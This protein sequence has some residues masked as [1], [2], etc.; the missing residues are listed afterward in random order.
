[1]VLWGEFFDEGGVFGVL[2]SELFLGNSER[3]VACIVCGFGV[4]FF[5]EHSID[6]LAP[7]VGVPL[8]DGISEGCFFVVFFCEVGSLFNEGKSDGEVVGGGVFIGLFV[9]VVEEG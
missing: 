2:F 5:V 3:G 4:G 9:E 6:D 8:F 7:V 1:M